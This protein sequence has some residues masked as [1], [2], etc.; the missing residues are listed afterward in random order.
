M[1]TGVVTDDNMEEKQ[2]ITANV[3]RSAYDKLMWDLR[4]PVAQMQARCGHQSCSARLWVKGAMQH[5][6]TRVVLAHTARSVAGAE[7]A[8]ASAAAQLAGKGVRLGHR[9]T[10][11]SLVDDPATTNL[12]LL[13]LATVRPTPLLCC[14]NA[15]RILQPW[16]AAA[17]RHAT[18]YRGVL[19]TLC[20]RR[21]RS[22]SYVHDADMVADTT[23]TSPAARW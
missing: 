5:T 3:R 19:S 10:R 6:T 8:P 1:T 11:R 21:I 23:S 15:V 13:I 7:G 20:E 17:I 22:W 16:C 9:P 2:R 4:K 18:W 14:Y 12:P